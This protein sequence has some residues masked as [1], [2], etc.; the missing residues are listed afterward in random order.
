HGGVNPP[1]DAGAARGNTASILHEFPA[2]P[3]GTFAYRAY[4]YIANVPSP[5]TDVVKL[6]HRNPVLYVEDTSIKIQASGAF[7]V[8]TDNSVADDSYH[9]A[10]VAAPIQQ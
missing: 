7:T 10:A 3:T 5:L 9:N 2:L 8:N 4:Y 6:R 1:D